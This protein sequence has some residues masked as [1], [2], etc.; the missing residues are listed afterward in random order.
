MKKL[1]FAAY[2]LDIGGIETAL[3]TLI[4]KLASSEK[5]NIT[6]VLEKKQGIFLDE[7]DSKVKIIEYSPSYNKIKILAKIS[8]AFLRFKF[9]MKYKKKFDCA[10]SYAT[11]S[12]PSSFVARTAS[13]NS[14]LWVHNEYM[15]VFENNKDEYAKFFNEINA[16][17]FRKIVFVSN[18]MR[19]NFE[20]ALGTTMKNERITI[21]NLVNYEQIIEKSQERIEDCKKSD[22]TTFLFVGRHTEYDKKISRLINACELLKNDNIEFRALIIGDG[23][24]SEMYKNMVN[25]KKLDRQIVFLGKKKNPYPYFKLSDCLVLTSEH[26]GFAIVY[27]EA[28]ILGLPII[29]TRVADSEALINGKYGIVTDKDEHSIYEAMKGFIKN[30]YKI[31]DEFNA[32]E[33]NDDII[34]KINNL[35]D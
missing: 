20:E 13:D 26:E 2:S 14:I 23:K 6:L 18:S 24:D 11:Y 31:K 22:I 21:Y 12:L 7:I 29:T 30:R 33:Y 5:Y 4:N 10:I 35:I 15:L 16:D 3:V 9:I 27:I 34:K 8:N 32:Q 19:N 1:L 28:L 25:E 17:K